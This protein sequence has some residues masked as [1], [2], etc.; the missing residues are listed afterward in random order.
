MAAV[1]AAWCLQDPVSSNA[2]SGLPHSQQG[3]QGLA[4]GDEEGQDIHFSCGSNKIQ[5]KEASAQVTAPVCKN[6][7]QGVQPIRGFVGD[8]LSSQ[9]G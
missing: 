4:W 2:S 8:A 7:A 1:W 6:L 5:K 3:Q 9:K